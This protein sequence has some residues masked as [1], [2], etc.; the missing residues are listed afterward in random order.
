MYATL[1]MRSSLKLPRLY[2]LGLDGAYRRDLKRTM[3]KTV[4][5]LLQ[6]SEISLSAFP[7]AFSHF[8]LQPS[9]HHVNHR[10]HS[11]SLFLA[12]GLPSVVSN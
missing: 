10:P 5:S 8:S 12:Y 4:L 11:L 7:Y 1:R 6:P 9:S 2:Y 3:L